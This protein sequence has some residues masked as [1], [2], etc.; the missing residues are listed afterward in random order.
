M[1]FTHALFKSDTNSHYLYLLFV[2]VIFFVEFEDGI[3]EGQG[4]FG[5]SLLAGLDPQLRRVFQLDR[6]ELGLGVPGAV[7]LSDVPASVILVFP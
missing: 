5:P 1:F 7:V 2:L 4:E 3:C 6:V